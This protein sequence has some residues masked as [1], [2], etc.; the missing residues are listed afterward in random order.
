MIRVKNDGTIW[1]FHL[2]EQEEVEWVKE[3]VSVPEWAWQ[4]G[5][6]FVCEPRCGATL[7]EG[8]RVEGGFEVVDYDAP[9]EESAPI[10]TT[11]PGMEA[12]LQRARA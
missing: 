6:N 11:L 5:T 1:I 7:I 8:L 12:W 9:E 2:S 3:N 10:E 4:N